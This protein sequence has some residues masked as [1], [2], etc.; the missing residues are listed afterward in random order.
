MATEGPSV[1]RIGGQKERKRG[2]FEVGKS[3]LGSLEKIPGVQ[4]KELII[5]PLS[6]DGENGLMVQVFGYDPELKKE[7]T[8]G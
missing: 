3:L 7:L 1:S 5:D 2:Q 6:P 4:I 8:N